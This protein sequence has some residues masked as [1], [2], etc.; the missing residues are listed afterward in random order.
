MSTNGMK[1][2][3]LAIPDPRRRAQELSRL[4]AEQQALLTDLARLRRDTIAELRA[5]GLTQAQ[6][7]EV[8]GV[9]PGRISQLE[10]SAAS[11]KDTHVVVERAIPTEPGI[12]ASRS[13]YLSE[14]EHQGVAPSRQMLKVGP[15]PAAAHIAARL[16]VAE[17]DDVVVRRKLMSANGIPI[18]ISG[19]YFLPAFAEET[20][21]DQA[22]FIEEGYQVLFE[23]HGRRFGHAV[24]TLTGRMPT[25]DEAHTLQLPTDVPVVEVLRTSYDVNKEHI[26]TLESV[27]AADKHVFRIRQPDGTDAF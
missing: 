27:C 12:R 1:K 8:L 9:S 6:V 7:A 15:E 5:A 16:G 13:L 18:R 14:T 25:H 21:L 11:P 23:R 19:S 17:G 24:E 20:G 2:N 10:P 4:V 3:L 22:D 26:H